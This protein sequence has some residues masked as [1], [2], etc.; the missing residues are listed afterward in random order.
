MNILV[1]YGSL[2]EKSINKALA[3]AIA[4]HKL[5]GMDVELCG[6][7]DLPLYDQDIEQ[8]AFPPE[9]LEF[10]RKIAEAEGV[11]IVT[12][13]YNRSMPGSL[14]NAIDWS[15]RPS[16]QHPWGGKPV[17]VMGASSGARGTIV[18]QYDLKRIMNYF[19]A[20]LM[21]N[22]EFHLDNSDEKITD[23]GVLQDEKTIAHLKKYLE[24]F[25]S[26]VEKP[27]K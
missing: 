22:P 9:A 24:S 25:K 12:P 6:V 10:K 2:R 1:I 19:G 23:D 7:G 8:S 16:G 14:K 17:G 13:E 18:A 5:D 26:H 4:E 27:I 20:H 15:S 21:G 11:I 3:Q